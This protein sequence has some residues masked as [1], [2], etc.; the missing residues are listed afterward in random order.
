MDMRFSF[1][2]NW[3]NYLKQFSRKDVESSKDHLKLILEI[4]DL[5][6]YSFLDVGS[7]SG[8]SSLAAKELGAEV[9]SF[10]YDSQSVTCTETVSRE[11]SHTPWPIKQGSVL[12]EKFMGSLGQF[13]IV[14]SWGVL[15]HTGGLE[16]AMENVLIPMKDKGTLYIALY[17]DQGWI[18]KYWFYVKYLYNKNIIFKYIIILIHAPYLYVARIAYRKLIKKQSLERGMNLWIDMLDW[19]GGYPFEVIKPECVIKFYNKHGLELKKSVLCGNRH[20]CNEFVFER[21]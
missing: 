20:G 1:G 10:D 13:D 15:H 12:D 18:S 7:G 2:K 9:T 8:L 21:N 3:G 6:S 16:K 14:Y 19:L 11:H 5:D 17:N 4:S